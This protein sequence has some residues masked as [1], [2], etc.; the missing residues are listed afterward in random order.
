M[1]VDPQLPRGLWPVGKVIQTNLSPDGHN[2][3]ADVQIKDHFH[4]RSVARLVVLP[5]LLSDDP[6]VPNPP[7]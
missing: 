1:I 2:R 6:G 7:E 4:T 5:T 3:S